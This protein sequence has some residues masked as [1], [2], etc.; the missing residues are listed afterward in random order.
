MEETLAYIHKNQ[1]RYVNELKEFLSIPSISNNPK[2]RPAMINCAE[3]LVD[4][5]KA[6]GLQ[7]AEL[8]STNGHPIV[9][10]EW[11]S[12]PEKPTLI[13]YGHYDVQPVD[14]LEL[15]TTNPFEPT[16]RQGEIYARGSVDDKGQVWM[17]LKAIEAYLKTQGNLPINLKVLI[18]GEEEVGSTNLEKFICS[19]QELLKSDVALISDTPMF[20]RGVP[21]I[22]YGLRG[23]A[24]FQLDMKGSNYD[25]HSGSFGGSVINPNFALAQVISL[26]KDKDGQI[27]IPGFYDDVIPLTNQEK[28]EMSKLPFDEA[29]FCKDFG[30]PKLFGEKGYGTLERIWARPTLEVNGMSGGFVGEGSKTVIP[31][32]AMAKISMRLVPNQDPSRVGQLLKAYL[33]NITPPSVKLKMTHLN[34]GKPWITPLNHPAIQ[35]ASQALK[36]GFGSAPVFVREGGSIPVVACFAA[37]L[38]IPTVLMGVG[39][40]DSNTHAPNEKL[41]LT[42]FQNGILSSTHFLS[43]FS[44]SIRIR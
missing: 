35:A 13:F 22:C 21:S 5:L 4:Q 26:L 34:G 31:A 8:F 37:V 14:P 25:L 3:F 44:N 29:I 20:K 9:F 33:Q 10:G 43:E 41:D 17:N 19:H 16:I 39:L 24:Y 1:N 12:S 27:L 2:N 36:K 38:G 40:P 23:L 28:I 18:E 6:I 15:W 32:H 30:I 42:N 11:L 7:R